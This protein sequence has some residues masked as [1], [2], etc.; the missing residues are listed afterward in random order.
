[1]S[2][3]W[4]FLKFKLQSSYCHH[5]ELIDLIFIVRILSNVT[6][7]VLPVSVSAVLRSC[8]ILNILWMCQVLLIKVNDHFLSLY[9]SLFLSFLFW[10]IVLFRSQSNSI[11]V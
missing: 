8:L 9:T 1:L 10:D 4:A 5:A 6:A 2:W 11:R 3:S 7:S